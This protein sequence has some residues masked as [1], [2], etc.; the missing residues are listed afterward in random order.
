MVDNARPA[1]LFDANMQS[2]TQGR[3]GPA[4]WEGR[5]L[6]RLLLTA[7]LSVQAILPA[8]AEPNTLKAAKQYGLSYLPLM[9]MEDQKLVEKHAAALGLGD[10]KVQWL[11]LGGPSAMNDALLSGGLD[12]AS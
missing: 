3:S 11:T 12:F 9:I 6:K 2:R 7:C 1:S 4:E 10:L 5:L 8:T